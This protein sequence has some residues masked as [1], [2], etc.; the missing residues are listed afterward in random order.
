VPLTPK[1]RD[2]LPSTMDILQAVHNEKQ[3]LKVMDAFP[4]M[5]DLDVA[6]EV[7]LLIQKGYVTVQK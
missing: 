1:L 2:L 4:E 3:L 6:M 5:T 7:V